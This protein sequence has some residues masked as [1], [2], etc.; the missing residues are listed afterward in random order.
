VKQSYQTF[1]LSLYAELELNQ[2]KVSDS[3]FKMAHDFKSDIEA[4]SKFAKK[5][6]NYGDKK[7]DPLP[8][9]PDVVLSYCDES[10]DRNGFGDDELLYC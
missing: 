6:A 1:Y 2:G 7:C 3:A 4:Y 9:W 5:Y 10:A 8:I